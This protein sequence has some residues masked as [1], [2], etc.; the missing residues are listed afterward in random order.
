MRLIHVM[1]W[2]PTFWTLLNVDSGLMM[3]PG[4]VPSIESSAYTSWDSSSYSS[5][6]NSDLSVS[7]PNLSRLCHSLTRIMCPKEPF[8]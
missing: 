3:Y 1:S 4:K 2:S 5:G 7:N 8:P 6:K